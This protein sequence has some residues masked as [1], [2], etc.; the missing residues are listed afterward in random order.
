MQEI[1]KT[2]GIEKINPGGFNG[3]WLIDSSGEVLESRSPINGQVIAK[4]NQVSNSDYEK[5]I[6]KAHDAFLEWR[7]VPAPKR[8][9]LVRQ[10]FCRRPGVHGVLRCGRTSAVSSQDDRQRRPIQYCFGQ[11]GP[12]GRRI[13]S[14]RRFEKQRCY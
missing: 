2:L 14:I 6:K 8:G 12:S 9:E 3:D 11:S 10:R 4:I 13:D 7:M 5:I 1:L